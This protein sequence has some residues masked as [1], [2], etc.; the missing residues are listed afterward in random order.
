M[1][2]KLVDRCSCLAEIPNAPSVVVAGQDRTPNFTANDDVQR[3]RDAQQEVAL[4]AAAASNVE[5][6]TIEGKISK[7][8]N[9]D[10]HDL[11]DGLGKNIKNATVDMS[12]MLKDLI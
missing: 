10:F 12:N 9:L 8:R 7:T 2:Y 5:T 6:E 1:I 11:I 3:S 4:A